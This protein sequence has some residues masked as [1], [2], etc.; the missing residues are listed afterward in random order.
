MTSIVSLRS[1]EPG[2]SIL[3]LND[4]ERLNAMSEEM[5]IQFRSAIRELQSDTSLKVLILEGAGR[6]FSA[7][8][9]LSM[10]ERK[11]KASVSENETAM[12]DFYKS[13][14]S[15]IGLEV[16]V[17]AKLHGFA[18]GAGLCISLACDLRVAS[19]DTK[20]AFNFVKLGLHPGMGASYFVPKLLGDAKARELLFTGRMFDA[21]SALAWGLVQKLS[22]SDQIDNETIV[23]AKEISEN[24]PI[25][26]RALKRNLTAKDRAELLNALILEAKAQAQD[27]AGEDFK[28]RL[29]N[30]QAKTKRN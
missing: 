18:V 30:A 17:I 9:D 2:I 21:E 7:G 22:S 25:A 12:I 5:A 27:Y 8:G 28:G 24:G 15:I 13:F 4:P 20:F 23:L 26:M 29:K 6:A 1:V 16:P 10:L 11:T 19:K 3:T 14:L